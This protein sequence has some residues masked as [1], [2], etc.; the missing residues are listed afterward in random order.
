MDLRQGL[1]Q[2]NFVV[3]RLITCSHLPETST[4]FLDGILEER[5]RN[6]QIPETVGVCNVEQFQIG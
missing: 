2:A 5:M 3:A 4:F 6:D 1:N